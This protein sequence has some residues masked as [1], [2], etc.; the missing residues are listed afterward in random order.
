MDDLESRAAQALADIDKADTLE[1]LDAL[2]VGLLGKSGIVTAALKALGALAPDERKAR[3]AEVNRVKDRLADAL[4]AR[5]Q[6]WS[7]PSWIAG[8]PPRSST[9][10]CLV[11]TASAAASIRSPARWSASR[12]SSRGSATSA[13][14][15]PRSRTTGTTSRR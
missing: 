1:A 5:K 10:A 9:S 13:P 15:V 2:R 3:G 8:W 6:C 7:R 14:T 12:R 4:A 11:A